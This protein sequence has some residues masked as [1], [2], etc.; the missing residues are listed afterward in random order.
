MAAR[1]PAPTTVVRCGLIHLLF[2][3][4]TREKAIGRLM[5]YKGLGAQTLLA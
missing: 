4:N 5:V 3:K 2:C 1:T